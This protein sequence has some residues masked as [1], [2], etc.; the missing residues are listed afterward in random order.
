MRKGFSC[1]DLGCVMSSPYM[2]PAYLDSDF[3]KFLCHILG[4]RGGVVTSLLPVL[5][6]S[7]VYF[8]WGRGGLLGEGSSVVA[9]GEDLV[10]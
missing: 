9:L 5:L 2:N 10:P 1:G 4:L 7:L 6:V 8:G 3:L